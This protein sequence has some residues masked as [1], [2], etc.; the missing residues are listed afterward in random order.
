VTHKLEL[1]ELTEDYRTT[2]RRAT[3]QQIAELEEEI[4]KW[5]PEKSGSPTYRWM[6]GLLGGKVSQYHIRA[7]VEVLACGIAGKPIWERIENGMTF[8]TATRLVRDAKR[9]AG[10]HN[11]SGLIRE[12]QETL[13][14]HDRLPPAGA[15]TDAP[16]A[17]TAESV[18]EASQSAASDP[19]K[20]WATLRQLAVAFATEQLAD[21]EPAEREKLLTNLSNDLQSALDHNAHAWSHARRAAK[22]GK[23][24]A[25]S[26][27]RDACGVLKIDPPRRG[28]LLDMHAA[29]SAQR[30]LA[31]L[32]HPDRNK[33]DSATKQY[34]EIN[35]A[36]ALL[37]RWGAENPKPESTTDDEPENTEPKR[38]ELRVVRG[39][40]S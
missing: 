3:Q 21:V 24:V 40:G 2:R 1:A 15:T 23:R 36:Y 38:P 39:S 6:A 20:F 12:V 16:A 4:A 19:R 27:M 34:N 35:S 26:S 31:R 14:L 13:R 11:L 17:L 18:A 32:Y 30:S 8:S 22:T 5:S 7:R 33:S 9:K 25:R 37:E 10:R 29:R 28:Q